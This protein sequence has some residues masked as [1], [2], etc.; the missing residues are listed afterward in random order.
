[1]AEKQKRKSALVASE[2]RSEWNY[3]RRILRQI[4]I[5]SASEINFWLNSLPDILM[6]DWT[7]IRFPHFLTQIDFDEDFF[8]RFSISYF[9]F[10]IK[11]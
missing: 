3:F 7:L 10:F 6:Q 4:K 9:F 8:L 2:A 11:L 5:Y 1:M